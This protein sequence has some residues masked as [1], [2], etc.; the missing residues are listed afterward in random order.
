MAKQGKVGGASCIC[1][2]HFTS[3]NHPF[4]DLLSPSRLAPVGPKNWNNPFSLWGQNRDENTE[5]R[6]RRHSF[7][8]YSHALYSAIPPNPTRIKRRNT[9][10]YGPSSPFSRRLKP[11][12]SCGSFDNAH[13]NISGSPIK[14]QKSFTTSL[15]YCFFYG[16][17]LSCMKL[18]DY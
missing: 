2:D 16:F 14:R 3:S 9:Q 10:L 1:H 4:R 15:G 18:S 5:K 11:R 13:G 6:P 17:V 7:H 8:V 12:Y